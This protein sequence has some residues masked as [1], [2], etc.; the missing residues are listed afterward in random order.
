MNKALF[1]VAQLRERKYAVK[2][3]F[4]ALAVAL[5]LVGAQAAQTTATFDVLIKLQPST[6]VCTSS[7]AAGSFGATVTVVCGTSNVV[8]ISAAA[9]A[10]P[11]APVH[12]GAYR[13]LTHISKDNLSATLDAY[14]GVGTS[15]AFRV[16][17]LADRQY[18]EMTVGW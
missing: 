11:F 18:I 6:G 16:V 12:G 5:T 2:A 4:I 17:S 7:N 14:S 13:F 1:A 3:K 8:G 10:T 15:T 9:S